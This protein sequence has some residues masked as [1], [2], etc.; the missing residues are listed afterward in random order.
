MPSCR[1]HRR[2]CVGSPNLAGNMRVLSCT[3]SLGSTD[4]FRSQMTA[5]QCLPPGSFRML[6]LLSF[7]PPQCTGTNWGGTCILNA[8]F[9]IYIWGPTQTPSLGQTPVPT[10]LPGPGIAAAAGSCVSF[11]AEMHL[12]RIRPCPAARDWLMQG[13][14]VH[15][16]VSYGD[17]TEGPPGP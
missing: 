3:D 11:W 4:S 8:P 7:V 15:R 13:Y 14:A 17:N 5:T 2:S 12:T 9:K 6:V 10:P 16:P 1:P